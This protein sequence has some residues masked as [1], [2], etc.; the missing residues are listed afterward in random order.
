MSVG[1]QIAVL[2]GL[3]GLLL[4]IA[5]WIL[6]Q[7]RI[8]PEKREHQRRMLVNS[9]GRLID[10]TVTE[11]NTSAIFYT[12]D[13]GGVGYTASQDITGLYEFLPADPERVIGPATIKYSPQNPANSIV[14][15]EHWS[16]LRISSHETHPT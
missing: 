7:Y 11:A 14:V 2:A 15:C 9:R 6:L 8:T 5:G 12:Y 1:A 16:G 13:V 10:G 4:A 3:A